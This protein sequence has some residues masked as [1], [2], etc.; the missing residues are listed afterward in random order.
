[1]TENSL[2]KV[3]D[4]WFSFCK[5]SFESWLNSLTA[6]ALTSGSLSGSKQPHANALM[7]EAQ[8]QTKSAFSVEIAGNL[9]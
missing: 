2:L 8:S 9:H 5:F 4:K 6:H 7:A 1:M 3:Q